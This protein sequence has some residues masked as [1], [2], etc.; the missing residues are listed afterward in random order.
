[1]YFTV[2]KS[3]K[4]KKILITELKARCPADKQTSGYLRSSDTVHKLSFSSPMKYL[5]SLKIVAE[6]PTAECQGA[7]A[8]Y[9]ASLVP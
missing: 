5:K 6:S 9:H 8:P 4:K 7:N 3:S 2:C 1:M